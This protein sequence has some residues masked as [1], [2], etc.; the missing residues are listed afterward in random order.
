MPSRAGVLQHTE[1]QKMTNADRLDQLQGWHA[2]S[3]AKCARCS[4]PLGPFHFGESPEQ[5]GCA[6]CGMGVTFGEKQGLD[7][8]AAADRYVAMCKTIPADAA[9]HQG[10]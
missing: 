6:P 3:G 7:I 9:S 10:T 5:W 2:H 8:N 1:K 4:E